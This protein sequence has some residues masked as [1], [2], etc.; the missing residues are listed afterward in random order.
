M[1]KG[2]YLYAVL[3]VAKYLTIS[4]IINNSHLQPEEAGDSLQIIFDPVMDFS[5]QHLLLSQ[6]CLNLVFQLFANC[7]IREYAIKIIFPFLHICSHGSIIYPYKSPV[8]SPY[9]VFNIKGF[10]L[11]YIWA[12]KGHCPVFCSSHINYNRNVLYKHTIFFFT[13]SKQFFSNLSFG[14]IG[15]CPLKSNNLLPL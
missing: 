14:Y 6:G 9:P 8:F 12:D 5:Q 11:F 1:D 3:N 13:L 15:H 2:D 7:N 4:V 10:I